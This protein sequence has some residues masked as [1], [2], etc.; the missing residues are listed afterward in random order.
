VA[1]GGMNA[2]YTYNGNGQRAKKNVNGTVTIF[3]YNL[4]GQIIAES[5]NAG[6]ITAEYVYLNG[7]PLA[8]M[9]GANTYYYHN[10]HLATPQ[11]MTDASGAVV[12]AADYK[13]FG[14]ATV[15]ISTITNNLRFPG[16][17]FDAETG[18]NYNYYRDYNP[19]IGKYLQADP[20]G[21]RGG[22]NPYRYV[23][24]NPVNNI[25]PLGLYGKNVH[26]DATKAAAQD[27]GYCDWEV[28][29]IARADQ[30]V[31][32]NPETSPYASVSARRLWHFPSPQR[33]QE[34]L[35]YAYS[36]CFVTDLGRALHVLQ[37]SYSH[38][39]FQPEWGHFW[40]GT[41]PDDI[42]ND[43]QKTVQMMNATNNALRTFLNR[44][45]G[46]TRKCS[47]PK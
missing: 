25:D 3:H 7:Q 29:A 14:E 43:M 33:V 24:N 32:D 41:S 36:S 34:L 18:L 2:G 35:T 6:T 28:A 15:T 22:V 46:A 1:D 30:G 31:D 10:D 26:F 17:Y 20:I 40:S 21:L 27:A 12:W 11:K 5:N 45:G 42:F 9:E 37:D 16:Q 39:G 4:N 47:C 23:Q 44:C 19:A 38:A 8:K 13:P